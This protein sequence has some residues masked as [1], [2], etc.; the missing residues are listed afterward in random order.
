MP[1]QNVL[2]INWTGSTTVWASND[3]QTN[4]VT[5]L[6]NMLAARQLT[7]QIDYVVLS[8]DIPFQTSVGPTLDSTTAALF[9]G[10]RLGNGTDPFGITNSYAASEAAFGQA[11]PVGAPGYS[12]L[13]TMIT[14]DSLADA[15]HWWIRVLRAMAHFPSNR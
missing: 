11:T 8:M 6:L 7:N 12:F 5:P 1:P 14:A 10:L 2:Y 3:F 9:Y 15:E 4:L 13:A